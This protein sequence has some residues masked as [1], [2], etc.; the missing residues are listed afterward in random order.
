MSHS[1]K[2]KHQLA[3]TYHWANYRHVTLH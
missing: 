2:Q 1:I 3:V